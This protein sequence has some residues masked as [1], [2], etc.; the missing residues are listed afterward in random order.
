MEEVDK[1]MQSQINKVK[2][3]LNVNEDQAIAILRHFQ[4]NYQRIEDD[5]FTMPE[6]KFVDIGLEYDSKLIEKY[7]DIDATR[8]ENNGGMCMVMYEEFEE[9]DPDYDS[10]ELICGH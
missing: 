4:W 10:D 2:E 9:G 8:K 1:M 7:P 5:W 6:R 3:L